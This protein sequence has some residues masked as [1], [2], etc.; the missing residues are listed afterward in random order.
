MPTYHATGVT[1]RL[2][3]CDLQASLSNVIDWRMGR[4]QRADAARVQAVLSA[5]R[6]LPER[7]IGEDGTEKGVVRFIGVNED[8]ALFMVETGENVGKR[9]QP[10]EHDFE[11]MKVDGK[12]ED[13]MMLFS[14]DSPLTSLGATPTPTQLSFNTSPQKAAP[15]EQNLHVQTPPNIAHTLEDALRSTRSLF[16]SLAQ[17][18]V[19]DVE[20]SHKSFLPP[21]PTLKSG[22]SLGKDLKA[23][24]FINGELADVHFVNARR[25]A[26]QHVRD[27][28]RFSGM[29]VHRQ[30]EVP[31]IYETTDTYP[32]I[33]DV[34]D[35]EHRW[36]SIC[37]SLVHEAEV[38]GR[39]R[40]GD[41]PPSAEFLMALATLDLP[42]RLKDRPGIGIIDVILT[43][44]KGKKY[45]PDTSYITGPTRMD[46]PEYTS[47]NPAVDPALLSLPSFG[48]IDGISLCN[49]LV[50]D[51]SPDT[52]LRRTR[53]SQA[54]ITGSP[55]PKKDMRNLAKELGL[56]L[57]PRKTQLDAYENASG[58][59]V[60]SR[61]LGQ[62][63]GDIKKMS[64][65]NQ[66]KE[67]EKLRGELGVKDDS[68]PV[69]K[70][71]RSDSRNTFDLAVPDLGPSLP[72][73]TTP[74]EGKDTTDPM[75]PFNP[76]SELEDD[77]DLD[78]VLTQTRIDM[79]LSEGAA[80]NGHLVPRITS[81]SPQRTP[82]R[83]TNASALANSPTTIA[84]KEQRKTGPPKTPQ[85]SRPGFAAQTSPLTS[86]TSS[87][88]QGD[89]TPTRSGRSARKLHPTEKSA[90]EV[91]RDFE[92]PEACA[93][94]CVTYAEDENAQRQIQK[95]RRGEFREEE[96]LVGMRFVVV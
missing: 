85:R 37:A 76:L 24:V 30:T 33:K 90:P 70:K 88:A 71:L 36:S 79:A 59:L 72:P 46:D 11:E 4:E 53:Q 32:L 82:K 68:E 95:E 58:K 86:F 16:D 3:T 34:K 64:E 17:A 1:A 7:P 60:R 26:V 51:S 10:T 87:K 74:T 69:K 96:L 62:R 27:K 40:L 80:S 31:W 28:I 93:G 78:A 84:V 18:L 77:A 52:P 91:L 83:R 13:A 61:T 6:K 42:R 12:P 45:G 56:D 92:V 19:L 50:P 75:S 38:R 43:V 47:S 21:N 48:A 73:D 49:P 8:M 81:M 54:T 14:D 35:A 29:R 5:A 55:T 39:D 23:E 65:Q 63:L 41:L 94:S 67:L 15:A 22:A 9:I 2:G 57:T 44:G 66:A 25:S 89:G 20:V